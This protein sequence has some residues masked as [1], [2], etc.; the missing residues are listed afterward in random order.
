MTQDHST[1][2][3][4]QDGSRASTV[5]AVGA[6]SEQVIEDPIALRYGEALRQC[7]EGRPD[8]WRDFA[9]GDALVAFDPGGD[10]EVRPSYALEEVVGPGIA[11]ARPCT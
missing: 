7:Q 9:A 10:T 6:R 2:S 5:V 11:R 3:R 4:D 8:R 1:H